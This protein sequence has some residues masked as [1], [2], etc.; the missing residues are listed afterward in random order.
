M[1]SAAESPQSVLVRFMPQ[2]MLIYEAFL[3][4]HQSRRSDSS[5][6]G[7]WK[8][9]CLPFGIEGNDSELSKKKKK[10][11]FMSEPVHI[12][13]CGLSVVLTFFHNY[14]TFCAII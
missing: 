13:L 8:W 5:Q 1:S 6:Q 7:G 12:M 14:V 3:I 4:Q 10:T 9:H 2:V 11:H